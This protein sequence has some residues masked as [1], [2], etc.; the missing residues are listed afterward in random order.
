MAGPKNT[1]LAIFLKKVRFSSFDSGFF[2]SFDRLRTGRVCKLR[3]NKY[4]RLEIV[5]K[6]FHKK[7][8]LSFNTSTKFGIM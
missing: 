2:A 7:V 3:V 5:D 4:L 6:K 1:F 8:I